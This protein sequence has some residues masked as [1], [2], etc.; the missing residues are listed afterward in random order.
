M[1]KVV[2]ET[3]L[4]P[5]LPQTPLP[6]PKPLPEPEPK[7]LPR[8]N[9][10]QLPNPPLMPPALALPP[11][12]AAGERQRIRLFNNTGHQGSQ[13]KPGGTTSYRRDRRN[14]QMLM[15]LWHSP[16]ILR[17]RERAVSHSRTPSHAWPISTPRAPIPPLR[18]LKDCV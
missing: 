17:G 5:E 6:N 15:A 18:K 13:P 8:P 7:P 4:L 12:T 11:T 3:I 16:D 1:V 10:E 2:V 14:L 9:P